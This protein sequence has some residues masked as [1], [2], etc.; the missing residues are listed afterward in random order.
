M[1]CLGKKLPPFRRARRPR[2]A[3]SLVFSPL[4][5][6]QLVFVDTPGIHQ[7]RHKLGEF[8]NYEAEEA[9]EGVDVIIWLVDVFLRT[10]RRRHPHR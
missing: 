9:A 10:D 1:R 5:N 4:E 8:L 2:A 6:A 7:A 3:V